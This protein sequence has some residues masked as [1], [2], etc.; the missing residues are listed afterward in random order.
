MMLFFLF[1]F[2]LSL[3]ML[4]MFMLLSFKKSPSSEK[5]TS[6]ECGFEPLSE[7][8]SPFSIRFFILIILFLIFDI[9]ISLLFPMISILMLNKK[10]E[11]VL[12][13]MFFLIILLFGIF[14]EWNEGAIDWISV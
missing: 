9:E 11:T 5:L 2:M 7:M 10:M 3:I 13:F 12:S 14:H 6:F 1:M 4:I 8:R